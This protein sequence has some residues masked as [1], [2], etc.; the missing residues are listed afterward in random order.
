M[1]RIDLTHPKCNPFSYITQTAYNVFRQKIKNEKRFQKTKEYMKDRY[2][3]EFEKA[4][5]LKSSR[6]NYDD[7]DSNM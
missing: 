5:N 3:D 1:D 7:D 6:K 2:F 4:N